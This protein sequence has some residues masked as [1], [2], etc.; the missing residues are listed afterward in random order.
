MSGGLALKSDPAPIVASTISRDVQKFD[1]LIDDMEAELGESWGDLHLEEARAFLDQTESGE[2][3]F[4]AIAVDQSD[5]GDIGL[6]GEII[7]GAKEKDIKVILIADD[8]STQGLHQLLKLG[9]DDFVPY[10]LPERALHDAI[11]RIREPEPVVRLPAP[12]QSGSTIDPSPRLEGRSAIFAVQSLAGGTGATTL[13]VNLAWELANIDKKKSPS[14]CL[15]DL[16]LQFGSASTFLDL[17]RREVIL[18]VLSDSQSMDVDAFKQA[19]VDYHG[20]MSVFTAPAEI[21]PLDMIGPED[22]EAILNLASECFDIVIIDMPTTIVQWTE[23]ILHRTDVFFAMLE[24]DM[25]SAQNAMRFIKALRSEDLPLE[26]VNFVLNR[27]P[28]SLD[29]NGKSR[30]KR[31]ADSLGVKISTQLS[32]GAKQITQCADHGVPLAEMAKKNPLRKDIMKLGSGLF[33]AMLSEAA[34][35]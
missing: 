13:A 18:E 19:L 33:N 21:I 25:R 7:R 26:K 24:L 32:D 22:V 3:E 5:E 4:V 27:A 6:I 30:V 8:L 34:T 29:L 16:D 31:L 12:P 9:A 23:T 15:I 17:P 14:V 35:G 20:K 11:K 10:P 1:L 2:L 28:K